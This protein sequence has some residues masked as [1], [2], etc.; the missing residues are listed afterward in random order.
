MKKRAGL[1]FCPAA[2]IMLIV[3]LPAGPPAELQTQKGQVMG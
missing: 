3:H 2:F 1:T